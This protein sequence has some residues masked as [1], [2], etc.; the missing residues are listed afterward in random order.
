M[1]IKVYRVELRKP[2]I[3]KDFYY[4][5]APSKRIARWCGANL[6]NNNFPVCFTA[7]SVK[8]TRY[9]EKRGKDNE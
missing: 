6:F 3:W 9:T 5:N 4:V 1:K 7:K 2:W 8:A